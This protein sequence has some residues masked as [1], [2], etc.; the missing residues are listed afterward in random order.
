LSWQQ[1]LLDWYH[2]NGRAYPWRSSKDPYRVWLSEIIL[3]QTRVQQGL[4]YYHR[5]L[6]RFP[7][8]EDLAA[9]TEEEVL[10]CWQ[11]LGYYSRARNLHHTAQKIVTDYGGRFPTNFESLRTLKGV[12]DYTASAIASICFNLPHAVVDGNVFRVL[13]RYYGIETPINTSQGFRQI[14]ALASKLLRGHDPGQFNQALMDFGA[15]HCTPKKPLCGDCPFQKNCVAYT[16][17]N[18]AKLPVKK[19]KTAVRKRYLHFLVVQTPHQTTALEQRTQKGIWHKLFQFPL[20]ETNDETLPPQENIYHAITHFA[21]QPQGLLLVNPEP[22]IHLLSHQ[23][24]HIYFW[25]ATVQNIH[26]HEVALKTLSEYPV[27]VVLEKF[28]VNFFNL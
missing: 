3:Q 15:H 7:T 1:H 11:G 27:P 24:L 22:L 23:K 2:Q 18:V 8:V 21:D 17:Q 6:E 16:T 28:M 19:G 26:T 5:F 25:Q 10:K 13:T 14:K 20:L 12:G 9:A 4:P